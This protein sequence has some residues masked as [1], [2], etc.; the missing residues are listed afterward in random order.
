MVRPHRATFPPSHFRPPENGLLDN[1]VWL[2]VFCGRER[3]TTEKN[4]NILRNKSHCKYISFSREV[5][6]AI[7]SV[8]K[9]ANSATTIIIKKTIN[10]NFSNKDVVISF[11]YT[12]Y[13]YTKSLQTRRGMLLYRVVFDS[14][15]PKIFVTS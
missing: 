13:T 9:C 6:Y 2:M 14:A 3:I 8:E 15:G 11:A 7:Y 5:I 12:S 1:F 10:T 4:K